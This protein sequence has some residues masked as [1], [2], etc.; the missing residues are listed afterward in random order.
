MKEGPQG[1]RITDIDAGGSCDFCQSGSLRAA[2]Y[3]TLTAYP[4]AG[5][6]QCKGLGK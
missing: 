1:A 5:G 6:E 4:A 2:L 3:E